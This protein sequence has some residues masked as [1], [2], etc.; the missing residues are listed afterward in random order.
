MKGNAL[1]KGKTEK[2]SQKRPGA[3]L[4]FYGS[5][6]IFSEKNRVSLPF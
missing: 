2:Y 1:S 6:M 5:Y 4:F 3:G